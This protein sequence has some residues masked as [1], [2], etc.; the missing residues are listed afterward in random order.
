MRCHWIVLVGVYGSENTAFAQTA[1]G[2]AMMITVSQKKDL[3]LGKLSV[4]LLS[5][6]VLFT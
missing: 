3:N 1:F 6:P 2:D 4:Q 5:D